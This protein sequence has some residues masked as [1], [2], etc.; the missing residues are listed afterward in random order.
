MSEAIVTDVRTGHHFSTERLESYLEHHQQGFTGPLRIRQ[1]EGGQSN[2]T[3]LLESPSGKYVLRKQPPGELLPSA[4]QVDREYRVMSALAPTN[5]PVPA[6]RCLCMDKGVIG[7]NF[8]VMDYVPS[9]IFADASLPGVEPEHRKLIYSELARNLA[10]LHSLDPR[11]LGIG[12]FGR[13]GNYFSR[14]ISRWARQYRATETE[15]ITSMDKLI[16]WLPDNVPATE[17][18]A[19]VHG[20][21]R[22]GNCLIDPIEPA[23][24]AVIDWELSTLGD[25][26]ADLGYV[27]Q[28][29]YIS[30]FEFGLGGKSLEQLGIPSQEE[31]IW[32]YCQHAG[33]DRVDNLQFSV[34]YNLF[35]LAGISQGV[36]KRGLEGNASS[37]IALT[38]REV[39]RD[40]ADTAWNMVEA[41]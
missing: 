39:V 23:I 35:R 38:F 15:T 8:Y 16:N 31:F 5:V 41:L 6:M 1:F 13:A 2:P 19:V 21:Y 28:M 34:I 22:I 12:D 32:E 30:T 33:I 14:Q 36:Y 7:A 27:Y 10:A 26:L 18:M 9:R 29:Y 25:P 37:E 3:F 17:K 24:A 20:D 40:Y 4:H 11:S